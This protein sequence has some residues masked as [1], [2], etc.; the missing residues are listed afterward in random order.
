V[1]GPRLSVQFFGVWVGFPSSGGVR[2]LSLADG[3]Y[4]A[5]AM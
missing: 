3:P 2:D 5:A 1:T 4:A